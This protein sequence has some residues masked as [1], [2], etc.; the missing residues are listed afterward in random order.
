MKSSAIPR[1]CA[2][3]ATL[4]PRCLPRI[5]ALSPE[6]ESGHPK[7][8]ASLGKLQASLDTFTRSCHK[9]DQ[10]SNGT[11]FISFLLFCDN[12][13]YKS[14]LREK[15]WALASSSEGRQEGRSR[16]QRSARVNC[17]S[18]PSPRPKVAA[19]EWCHPR[20]TGF[21]LQLAQDNSLSCSEGHLPRPL[22]SG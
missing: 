12:I 21:P 16:M 13:P 3:V 1:S 20:W 11:V 17:Y 19:R 2:C 9:S 15:V 8:T 18:A 5:P 14:S 7:L 6:A 10:R 22:D 4:V